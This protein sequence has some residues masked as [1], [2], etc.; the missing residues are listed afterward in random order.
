M[1]FL[2]PGVKS[3][4]VDYSTYVGQ[5]SSCIAGIVGGGSKG[6][7]G[8][9][10]L[11]T[12]PAN[13]VETFGEPLSSDYGALAALE[14]L[15]QGNQLYYTRQAED[16]VSEASASLSGGV[17]RIVAKEKGSFYNRFSADITN[18]KTDGTFTLTL[19][20]NSIEEESFI[21]SFDDSSEYFVE[22]LESYWVDFIYED[23]TEEN[24]PQIVSFAVATPFVRDAA[25]KWHLKKVTTGSAISSLQFDV[26]KVVAVNNLIWQAD[27]QNIQ[28]PAVNP[29]D[30]GLSLAPTA[31]SLTGFSLQKVSNTLYMLRGTRLIP[32]T[33]AMFAPLESAIGYTDWNTNFD[34]TKF[35]SVVLD[36]SKLVPASG[37][38]TVVQE[39]PA[40]FEYYGM[41]ILGVNDPL[42]SDIIADEAN[43]TATKTKSFDVSA[44]NEYEVLVSSTRHSI[45][46]TIGTTVVTL[47]TS[48]ISGFPG[49]PVE[50]TH[51]TAAAGEVAGTAVLNGQTFQI[52]LTEPLDFSYG[53]WSKEFKILLQTATGLSTEEHILIE[54]VAVGESTTVVSAGDGP[55]VIIRDAVTPEAISDPVSLA[56]GTDGLPLSAA[57]VIGHSSTEGLQA[58][59]NTDELD[60]NILAAPGHSEA[61]VV[62]QLIDVAASRMDAVAIVDPP[63]G[64]SV[65]DV[66]K[67]HNGTLEGDD[68][69]T[70]ALNSSYAALFY[71][72]VKITDIYS[73]NDVWTPPS[74]VV[75]GAFAYNDNV[76]QPWFAPAGLNRGMLNS[77]IDVERPLGDGD[78]DALYGNGNRINAIINYKKQGITIWGQCT[79]QRKTSATDRINVRRLM[80][81]VRKTIAISTAYT[82]FEQNDELTWRKWVGT[83]E[84]SLEAIKQSR[85]LYAYK[86]VMDETTVTDY[87]K[88]RNEMP[89][90]IWL[91]PTKTA[92]FIPLSFILTSSGASFT[93]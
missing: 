48:K 30:A 35:S 5:I 52:T 89:G 18:V 76:G 68:Y 2:S 53:P 14:F 47:D 8:E 92:E 17:L 88:D 3:Q 72:W 90:Q 87:Y 64:L 73:G 10:T 40:I 19:Y 43:G 9:P 83:V 16:T 22:E 61:S 79:L 25:D 29:G 77:V 46:L 59:R 56:G 91:Q 13:F 41:G 74:G 93:E 1:I 37:S 4:E 23:I 33:E 82:V 78:R 21:A 58:Y 66:I 42:Y 31:T 54:S 75:M 39:N 27:N 84:P 63:Q 60:V 57:T 69:P 62:N 6:P 85:G 49:V 50:D 81:Y 44:L 70:K 7:I 65:Q 51:V 15:K 86:V 38:V 32:A 12:S 26:N 45:K 34:E 71:P 67:W 28:Y 11:C 24:L 20:K 80:N 36:L 55:T